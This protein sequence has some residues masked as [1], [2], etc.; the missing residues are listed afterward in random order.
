VSVG[1]L[2]EANWDEQITFYYETAIAS[3]IGV[4]RAPQDQHKEWT[5]PRRG[6]EME[7]RG[8]RERVDS[9]P[10]REQITLQ[11]EADLEEI[12]EGGEV[13]PGGAKKKGP[14]DK[15]TTGWGTGFISRHKYRQRQRRPSGL[16]QHQELL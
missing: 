7:I 4:V 16:E 1:K 15:R 14:L 2:C 5:I 12:S 9:K 11:F 10:E 13:P 8:S 6:E 3:E